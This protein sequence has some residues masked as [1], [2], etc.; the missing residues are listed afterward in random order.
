MKAQVQ[1][2]SFYFYQGEFHETYVSTFEDPPSAYPRL[3]GADEDQGWPRGHQCAPRQGPQAPG[4]LRSAGLLGLNDLR[5][6]ALRAADIDLST[7]GDVM[8]D[9]PISRSGTLHLEMLRQP[10]AFAAMFAARY[11]QQAEFRLHYRAAP[12]EWVQDAAPASAQPRC[13]LGL[14]IPKKFCKPAVRRNL[15]KRVMRQALRELRLPS[16]AQLQAPV[17]MLRLTRKLPAEFR[18]ARS[19]VLLAY[20]QQAV[21]ALLKSWIERTV[22]VTGRSAA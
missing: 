4:C 20:V 17:L 7:V 16:E 5:L 13:W 14:V 6:A 9:Q 15:I 12:T 22:V 3:F 10:E 21:N 18:S 1:A 2:R 8:A 19:P 11:A